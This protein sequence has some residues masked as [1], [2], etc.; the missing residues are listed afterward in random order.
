MYIEWFWW[1]CKTWQVFRGR[2]FFSFRNFHLKLLHHAYKHDKNSCSSQWLS[3]TYTFT[4][5]CCENFSYKFSIL[6]HEFKFRLFVLLTHAKRQ[7]SVRFYKLSVIIQ[8]PFRTEYFWVTPIRFVHMDWIQIDQDQSILILNSN[9]N[10]VNSSF[11]EFMNK[12]LSY[13]WN[14]IF[15]QFRIDS[16]T[17]RCS[18]WSNTCDPIQFIQYSFSIRHS[19]SRIRAYIA[20]CH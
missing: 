2:S 10:H 20:D 11:H 6:A 4:Y 3:Q 1:Y 15:H 13:L 5:I 16:R 7:N 14:V 18:D 8:K 17:M 12:L 9:Q 19:A